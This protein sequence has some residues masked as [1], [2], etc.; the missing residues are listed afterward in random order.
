MGRVKKSKASHLH[1]VEAH[2][3]T[4]S[5]HPGLWLRHLVSTY[6]VDERTGPERISDISRTAW[7]T[8][9]RRLSVDGRRE[10]EMGLTL[11]VLHGRRCRQSACVLRSLALRGRGGA[12]KSSAE[13]RSVCKVWDCP[14]PERYEFATGSVVEDAGD[15][16]LL[17]RNPR[18]G[19][20]AA[21]EQPEIRVI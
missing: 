20:F 8:M 6:T 2:A 21:H 3:P 15:V 5:S 11:L 19:H 14:T 4:L 10:F 16:V 12:S 18:G 17:S 13:A 9:D 1:A 7:A